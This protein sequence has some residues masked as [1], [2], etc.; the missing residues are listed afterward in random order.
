MMRFFLFLGQ[1]T[2]E[3]HDLLMNP[4]EFKEHTVRPALQQINDELLA[5][6]HTSFGHICVEQGTNVSF[7]KALVLVLLFYS[8]PTLAVKK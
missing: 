3:Y 7:G 1:I 8:G 5:K 2:L 4:A 6:S